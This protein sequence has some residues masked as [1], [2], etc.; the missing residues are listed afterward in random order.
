MELAPG[1]VGDGNLLP[2]PRLAS[3]PRA[4]TITSSTAIAA[5]PA[6]QHRWNARS[7]VC[8]VERRHL[9]RAC[10]PWQGRRPSHA[11]Y[12]YR[13]VIRSFPGL[14]ALVTGGTPKTVGAFYDVAYDRVLAPPARTT[15]NR[16]GGIPCYR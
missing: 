1:C 3:P 16:A 8:C 7:P 11:P 15:G 14:M 13:L 12:L 10:L 6:D 4:V 5:Y 9:P 2:T